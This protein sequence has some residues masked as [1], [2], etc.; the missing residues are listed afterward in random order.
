MEKGQ[1]QGCLEY[2]TKL[3][4]FFLKNYFR[5]L[6]RFSFFFFLLSSSFWNDNAET[7]FVSLGSPGMCVFSR[8]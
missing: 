2:A 3:K 4:D 8:V 1:S 5:Q 6:L 7:V